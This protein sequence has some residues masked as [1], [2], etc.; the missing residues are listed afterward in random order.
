MY[1][2]ADISLFESVCNSSC[3]I[4]NDVFSDVVERSDPSSSLA[5]RI[6]ML[7]ALNPVEGMAV[8]ET[9][10]SIVEKIEE[11]AASSSEDVA[12]G[13]AQALYKAV[14][15]LKKVEGYVKT[16][17]DGMDDEE[18]AKAGRAF[19]DKY[20]KTLGLACGY[21]NRSWEGFKKLRTPLEK[22]EKK[23]T[24]KSDK[25]GDPPNISEDTPVAVVGTPL[26]I[27]HGVPKE[28]LLSG[29]FKTLV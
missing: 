12:K 22:K 3:V 6:S 9:V 10:T 11:P 20:T 14:G 26:G 29:V 16:L 17:L 24:K 28:G 21:A 1:K 4:F 27:G 25:K 13:I 15:N 7:S 8:P 2:L 5:E 19:A 23:E 18:T